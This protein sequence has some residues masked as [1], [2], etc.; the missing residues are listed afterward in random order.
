MPC[1]CAKDRYMDP[2]GLSWGPLLWRVLHGLAE[3]VGHLVRPIF[4]QDEKR[5]W[6]VLLEIIAKILPCD[7]CQAHYTKW[8]AAHPV[9]PIQTLTGD[10]LREFIRTWLWTL[11][12][13]V[14]KD[15]NKPSF[16]YENLTELY[17]NLNVEPPY[18]Y[19]EKLE[20]IAIVKTVVKL[21][22]WMIFVK[23]YRTLA[24]IYGLV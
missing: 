19:F 2:E 13:N 1:G 3:R 6:R 10:A 20:K 18:K 15:L 21:N 9:S 23:E 12:E 14:N 16:A 11:H 7:V 24:N 5:S 22:Q 17:G 8:L 4:L